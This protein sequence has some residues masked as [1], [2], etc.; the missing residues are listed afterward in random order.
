[1]IRLET[2]IKKFEDKGEKTGWRYVEVP[3]AVA[4]ELNGNDKRSF[5]VK[6]HIDGLLFPGIALIPMGAG[7]YILPVNA[8]IRKK[9]R[10]KEGAMVELQLEKDHSLP[11]LPP[12]LME[13][14]EQE[15]EALNYFMQLK[16]GERNYFIKWILSAK[17]DDTIAK[18]MALVIEAFT[19][20]TDFGTMI[21]N[22][23]KD[24][25]PR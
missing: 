16:Q 7:K 9:I 24:K 12:D 17:T 6:V 14:L 22:Q 4:V 25:F 13:G 15:Q 20:K 19:R 21:R 8:D 5:R 11:E 23:R 1:M 10:K 18:R 3:A 2:A